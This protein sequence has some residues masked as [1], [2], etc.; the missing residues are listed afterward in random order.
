M[1]TLSDHFVSYIF[2]HPSNDAGS[3]TTARKLRLVLDK[4][5]EEKKGKRKRSGKKG[6]KISDAARLLAMR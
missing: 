4:R 3:S 1:I 2:N 5:S 6:K